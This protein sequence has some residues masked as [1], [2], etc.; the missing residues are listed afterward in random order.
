MRDLMSFRTDAEGRKTRLHTGIDVLRV[1]QQVSA[2]SGNFRKY[3]N[4]LSLY[5]PH[6]VGIVTRWTTAKCPRVRDV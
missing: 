3:P 4:P 6:Y 1:M 5:H 2:L